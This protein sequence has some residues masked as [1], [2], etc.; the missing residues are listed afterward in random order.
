VVTVIICC[1]WDWFHFMVLTYRIFM[2]T[3]VD[4]QLSCRTFACRAKCWFFF[5]ML[6]QCGSELCCQCFRG[7]Y[8]VQLLMVGVIITFR[9]YETR[10]PERHERLTFKAQSIFQLHI[11]SSFTETTIHTFSCYTHQHFWTHLHN[12]K[13]MPNAVWY[14]LGSGMDVNPV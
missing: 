4:W 9:L 6:A 2:S 7:S 10:P 3:N 5:W 12:Y 14:T 13:L 11:K 8:H 1:F